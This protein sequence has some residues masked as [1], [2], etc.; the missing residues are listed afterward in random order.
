MWFLTKTVSSLTTTS[1]FIETI[2]MVTENNLWKFELD[3]IALLEF[4]GI[5][6]EKY[7][8]IR[9]SGAKLFWWV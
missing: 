8:A 9:V 7:K 5:R 4:T 3:S 2:V 6:S 1:F